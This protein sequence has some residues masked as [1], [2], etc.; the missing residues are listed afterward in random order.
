MNGNTVHDLTIA[1]ANNLAGPDGGSN[2]LS[3]G[4]IVM[5][6]TWGLSQT[7]YG[8]TVYNI[9]NTYSS[10]TGHV[11]GIY[12]NGG[13]TASSVYGNLVYG[14][15]VSSGSSSA[16]A[17]GIKI[18]QGNTTFSNN[19][20]TLGGNTTTNLYGIYDAGSSGTS[21]IYFNTVYL[22]GSPASGSLNSACLYNAANSNTRNYRNNIFDNAR[23]NNGASGKHYALYFVNT[24]NSLTCDYN[25]Y[26][27][28]GTGGM[29]GYYGGDKST[30]PIVTGQDVNSSAT[31]PGFQNPGGTTATSYIPSAI[32]PAVIGTGIT[33]DYAGSTR[34]GSPEIGA[35]ERDATVS[36]T[37]ATST[38]WNVASNWNSGAVPT[39]GLSVIIPSTSNQPH[40]TQSISSPTVCNNLTIQSGAVLTIDPGKALTVYGTLTNNEGN[41]GLVIQ[42]SASGT[43]SLIQSSSSVGAT[44]QRYITG[45]S[46]L[47]DYKYHFVSIPVHYDNPTSNLF[48]HSYLYKLDPTQQD[49]E[50]NNYYGTWVNLGQSTTTPLSCSSGY[51]IYYPGSSITYEF[52]G[53]LNTGAFAA[54]VAYSGTWTFNLVPNPFP[55]AINWGAASG[56]DRSNIGS[57]AWIWNSATGNYTTLSGTSYI[58]AGQAFIVLASGSP[59]LTVSNAVCTHNTQAFYK[60]GTTDYLKISAQSNDYY[61]ETFVGFDP[62]ATAGFDLALDGFKLW[63]QDDA[64]QL[65]TE[66][67]EFRMSINKVPPPSGGLVI[68]VDFKTSFS[69]PVTLTFSGADSFDPDRTIRFFD[70]LTGTVCDLRRQSTYL[71]NHNPADNQKRFSLVFGNPDGIDSIGSWDGR[72]WISG[73]FVNISPGNLTGKEAVLEIFNLL[74]Q[75]LCSSV[76][77]LDRMVTFNPGVKGMVIARLTAGGQVNA[78]K[79]FLK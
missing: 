14:I 66:A 39:S 11:A 77:T 58:P 45:S 16:T 49:P 48:L 8:N 27:V 18:A 31:L 33:K 28:S 78:T 61:D 15:T 32:L 47:T 73:S 35:Y 62:S 23:S 1:N 17:S 36:W 37:G 26:Y 9:S 76:I 53:N 60:S 69:G 57:T 55:S 79:G 75:R 71:F 64:P 7:I 6:S 38:D 67:V 13:G 68:P 70:H 46:T 43:G 20:I 74:G 2:S 19:I 4:G 25:N 54:S 42:S 22:N 29:L 56:W 72:F 59:S 63:G 41:A 65:W 44:V 40:I 34:S 50:N 10:F 3:A 51:M 52:T 30:T 24:G 21:N 12:Y 5:S